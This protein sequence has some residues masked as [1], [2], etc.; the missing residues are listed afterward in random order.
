MNAPISSRS[1]ML[2]AVLGVCILVLSACQSRVESNPSENNALDKRGTLDDLA[3]ARNADD[4]A[5]NTQSDFNTITETTP[6]TEIS[7]TDELLTLSKSQRTTILASLYQNILTTEPNDEVRTQIF[8]RLAQIDSQAYELQEVE[9][10]GED[11]SKQ[12]EKNAHALSALVASYRSL[13]SRYPNRPENEEVHYQL[14]KALDRQ[15]QLDQSL[16]QIE[17][18]LTKYPESKYQAELHFRRGDIYYN[19]QHY[20]KALQEYQ[21]VLQSKNSTNYYVNS[22]Y[23]SGWALFKLNRL[24]ESDQTFLSLLD[25]I[26]A[27]EKVQPNENDFSFSAI[28]NRY[29]DLVNDIQR[30]LSISLSQQDQSA[31]LVAL[32]NNYQGNEFND[33]YL[34]LYRHLLFKN[35]ADFLLEN[36][37]TYDAELTYQSYVTM[38]PN[39]LWSARYM[40]VL[41]ELYRTQGKHQAIS[42]LKID[43]VKQFGMESEFWQQY[44]T[45]NARGY[46]HKAQLM[47]EVLPNLLSFSYQ[48]S[49][50][51]YAQAQ[52]ETNPQNKVKAF[53]QTAQWLGI[54]LALA[55]QPESVE[56]V[57][58]I[59][60]SQGLLADELLF[61]D[62]SFEAQLYE[63]ALT[64]YQYIAYQATM[65]SDNSEQMR[66]EAA[67]AST[68][69]TRE[70]LASH[71]K[72]NE[73]TGDNKDELSLLRVRD[74]LDKAFIEQYPNDERSLSLA[75]QQ[76]QY[77]WANKDYHVMQEYCDFILQTYGV[78]ADN[79]VTNMD[80]IK[81]TSSANLID[82]INHHE[83]IAKL[84]H[85][86]INQIQIASQLQANYWYQQD[87]YIQAETAYNLALKYVSENSKAWTKM[88]ELLAAS[89]YFQGQGVAL[90]QPLIAVE[91]Y[92]RLGKK[93]PESTYRLNAHFEAANLLFSQQQWQAAIETYLAFQQ[94]YPKNEYSRSIP[95]KLAESYESLAQWQKAA[96]QYLAIVNM[97]DTESDSSELQ[98]EALYNA[99]ELYLKADNID[100]AIST[101]RTYAHTYPEPF[102]VAQE[103][104]FKMTNFYNKTKALN[105]AYYW[106]RKIIS[107]YDKQ[108]NAQTTSNVANSRDK[109]LASVAALALGQAHQATF[110]HIKLTLPLNKSLARKQKAMK[111]AID[112][113]KKLLSFELAEFVPHGTYNLGQMYRQ[114]SHDVMASQR[115]QDL[116]EFALEEYNL[117]LEE[118]IYPFE[119]KAIEIH[120][121][122]IKRAWNN[123]YDEWV[124]K[125]FAA[126]A[127]LEPALYHRI[128]QANK[129][130]KKEE[131][132]DVVLTL[133]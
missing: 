85:N 91:H 56:F 99:A 3:K 104:R 125:S 78:I 7:N 15:G 46:V 10:V 28:D 129:L 19:L 14:A 121:S 95:A 26:I 25:F 114:L 11:N 102:D 65:T 80:V 122:N 38:A 94:N 2:I 130:N 113:Y 126:L 118:M 59:A 34:Y 1:L 24:A 5:N 13:I 58:E 51:L 109:Y 60:L 67:Y 79:G 123:T 52:S 92:L 77:S 132:I 93:I 33:N 18:I 107:F 133:H 70:I 29:S 48:H 72:E 8:Y 75:L 69:T 89:I 83:I 45:E 50:Y 81:S 6:I 112:Y 100:K 62:A 9:E 37:L 131:N 71:R 27:Q 106:H 101:F 31:S 35:L 12:A 30:V 63:Q 53:T 64:S 41:M 110:T 87:E 116:D 20:T 22:V 98:Q 57:S 124:M 111:T 4:I 73:E 108:F 40:L 86:A 96:E 43:Y 76:A 16:L 66:K 84:D 103:V 21:A 115:P 82:D 127:A 120:T 68:L 47:D 117:L 97:A 54:Y 17:L 44:I 61:A 55:K 32:V 128:H 105:K 42:A 23:M 119:E 74:Q 36:G 88:R 39:S 49:R 90:T